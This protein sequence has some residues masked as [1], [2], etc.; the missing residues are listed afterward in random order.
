MISNLLRNL[1][2][3][4]KNLLIINILMFDGI[5]FLPQ[6]SGMLALHNIGS[7]LFKPHQL[8]THIFMHGS[9]PHLFFNMFA[10]VMF[11]GQLEKV[12]GGKKFLIIYFASAAGALL[13]Q[14]GI[15]YYN[16]A[17]VMSQYSIQDLSEIKDI[18]TN[19][20]YSAK[21]PSVLISGIEA[22][23]VNNV[24]MVGA[25]GAIMGLLAGFGYLFPNTELYLYMLFP[26]KAKIFIPILILLDLYLGVRN[27]E[28][29]NVAHFAHLGGAIAGFL[30][31]YFWN[32]KR[33]NFY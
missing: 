30:L 31:V 26:V 28:F 5:Y 24:G 13:L 17:S 27:F 19:I 32:K 2:D 10:L 9:L 4:T 14:L 20:S 3:V 12:W 7:E 18:V 25:S 21:Y 11:G 22:E 6:F 33:D 15:N 16:Y 1:P 29:D 23:L 8:L